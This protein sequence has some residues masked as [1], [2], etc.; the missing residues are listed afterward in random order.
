MRLNL[1]S[2]IDLENK[3]NTKE[4]LHTFGRF[5]FAFVRFPGINELTVVLTGDVPSFV[6]S[7][8]IISP[9]ELYKKFSSGSARGLV[10]VHFLA[11]LIFHLWEVIR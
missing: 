6:G 9:S 10:C 11:S 3:S 1:Y 2:F 5:F 4:I 8:D 7:N